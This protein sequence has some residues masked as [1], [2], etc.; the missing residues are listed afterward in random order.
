MPMNNAFQ[1]KMKDV[2]D[3]CDSEFDKLS[4]CSVHGREPAGVKVRWY[5][6]APPMTPADSR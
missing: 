5:G 3:C 4:I 2:E 1:K 6:C